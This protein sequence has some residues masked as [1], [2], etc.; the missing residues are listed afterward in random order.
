VTAS[1]RRVTTLDA[2]EAL[3]PA[4]NKLVSEGGQ[5]S[6]FLTHEWFSCCWRAVGPERRP[7]ILVVED[8]GMPVAFVPLVRRRERLRGL[9]VRTLG[10]LTAPDTPVADI[11]GSPMPGVLGWIFDYLRCRRDWDV[12]RLE[13]LAANSPTLDAL[14]QGTFRGFQWRRAGVLASPYLALTGGWESF[15]A[16]KSPRFKK[17]LRNN[18]NRLKRMGQVAVE[19]HRSVDSTSPLFAEIVEL[20]ARS[21]KGERRL[22]IATMP[23]MREFFTELTQRAS[24]R[25]WLAVWIL[26][27]DGRPIAME[28]HIVAGGVAHALRADFDLAFEEL[29]PGSALNHAIAQALF[30]R[31]DLH[32]YDMGPGLNPY[33]LRWATGLRETVTLTAF[34]PAAYGRVLATLERVIVPAARSVVGALR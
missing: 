30:A 33:K 18:Q 31:G 19:E 29:S 8:S 5:R 1:I 26:R 11:V 15:Y 16:A 2:Y 27:L 14:E 25:G 21:W 7:E 34:R 23:R 32:E 10:F 6:P 13:K 4:W 3:A 20:T 22:A 17:T 12:L 24:A 9:P 28:Y